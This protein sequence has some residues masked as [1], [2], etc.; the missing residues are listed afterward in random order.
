MNIEKRLILTKSLIIISVISALLSFV[1]IKKGWGEVYPF[2][3]WKLYSQPIGT[4][5]EVIE[6]RIYG[7][8]LN[9]S[10]FD[11]I[12]VKDTGSFTPDEY[13]YTFNFLINETLNDSLNRNGFK[14][15]LLLFVR[16]VSPSKDQYKVVREVYNP[17]KILLNPQNYDT[18]TV[19][20]F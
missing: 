19:V 5:G 20:I 4:K 13:V 15:K 14:E 6:Y 10:Q 18:T 12:C 9:E 7:K 11:R 3:T 16:H 2:F 8:N 17:E 1:T